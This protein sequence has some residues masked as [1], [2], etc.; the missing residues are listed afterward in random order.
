[1]NFIPPIT[2]GAFFTPEFMITVEKTMNSG[3]PE[4]DY[5]FDILLGGH[6]Y[7]SS[8]SPETRAIMYRSPD[9]GLTWYLVYKGNPATEAIDA[10][11]I[12][13]QMPIWDQNVPTGTFDEVPGVAVLLKTN[14]GTSFEVLWQEHIGY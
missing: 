12:T 11:L 8:P 10:T 3:A 7:V 6:T 1:M 4:N 13:R 2:G 9:G 14:G 5:P